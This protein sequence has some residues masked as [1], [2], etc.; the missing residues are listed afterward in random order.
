[1]TD[2][3]KFQ[4]VL[5]EIGVLYELSPCIINGTDYTYVL[6]DCSE[7]GHGEFGFLTETGKYVKSFGSSYS[8]QEH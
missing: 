2:L 5:W 8:L 3:E 7:E 4:K 1:M 6:F